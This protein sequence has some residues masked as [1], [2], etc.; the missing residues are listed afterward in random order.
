L[1]LLGFFF[2]LAPPIISGRAVVQ[3]RTIGG[4]DDCA[5]HKN[6]PSRRKNAI[7]GVGREKRGGVK[8]SR[9]KHADSRRRHN[10]VALRERI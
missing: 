5:P 7:C 4:L 3:P 10:H 9:G 2:F 8:H 1:A 6:A